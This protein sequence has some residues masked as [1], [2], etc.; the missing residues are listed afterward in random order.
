MTVQHT[1]PF[2]AA[3]SGLRNSRSTISM[4][5]SR[6]ARACPTSEL[7]RFTIACATDCSP[8]RASCSSTSPRTCRTSTSAPST[9]KSTSTLTASVTESSVVPSVQYSHR[10]TIT[11]RSS[12]LRESIPLM[13]SDTFA[14][15]NL[16]ESEP[17]VVTAPYGMKRI[18]KKRRQTRSTSMKKLHRKG[19]TV[20]T[21]MI[22]MMD[23]RM[24]SANSTYV[25]YTRASSTATVTVRYWATLSSSA[26]T[27]AFTSSRASSRLARA[28]GLRY[29]S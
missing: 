24:A 7:M 25:K 16:Q 20:H 10:L 23:A 15:T 19:T 27:V 11:A 8:K 9:S 22:I 29:I 14:S 12:S 5:P 17:T 13:T 1:V 18:K 26:S 28:S 3:Y 2:A 4:P 6:A 21:P